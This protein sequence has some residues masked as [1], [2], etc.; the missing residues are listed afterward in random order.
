VNRRPLG[1]GRR[2]AG[3][4]ALVI[5]VGSVL[6]WYTRGGDSGLTP[7]VGNAFDGSG[8]LVF[9]AALATLAL[10]T[11]PYAVGDRPVAVDRWLAY[12]LLFAIA[13]LGLLGRVVDV[14][15]NGPLEAIRPDRAPGLVIVVIGV[16]ALGRAAFEM[17]KAPD[18]R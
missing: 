6:P 11:L 8:I 18:G 10:I 1:R 14:V 16:L 17:Y 13:G 5:I 3:L 2:L 9:L 4:A 15:T 7:A 12:A